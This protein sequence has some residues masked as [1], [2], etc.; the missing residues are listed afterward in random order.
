MVEK[1]NRNEIETTNVNVVSLDIC[2]REE[3]KTYNLVDC[4]FNGIEDIK[5]LH[6]FA[7]GEDGLQFGSAMGNLILFEK[8]ES[9]K[10]A[11][12]ENSEAF[13]KAHQDDIYA[14]ECGLMNGNK[15]CDAL[16]NCQEAADRD[17]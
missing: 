9:I 8:I 1:L 15:L 13:R 17:Y 4:K 16:R 12:T 5:T 14:F 6:I 7:V 10:P 2:G 11:T 3:I